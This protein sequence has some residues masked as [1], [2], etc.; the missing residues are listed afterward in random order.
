MS[1]IMKNSIFSMTANFPY[2]FLQSY[3]ATRFFITPGSSVS[4][5][6]PQTPIRMNIL[7][8]SPMMASLA[9][10]GV[11]EELLKSSSA[12]QPS[13][14]NFKSV[15]GRGWPNE[16]SAWVS[17]KCGHT[18]H[19]PATEYEGQA[20]NWLMVLRSPSPSLPASP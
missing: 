10:P 9:F 13:S 14:T 15:N 3:N 16:A 7:Y 20:Q 12:C 17:P 19:P 11:V 5:C 1:F 6:D 8:Q 4:H 2:Y 18:K